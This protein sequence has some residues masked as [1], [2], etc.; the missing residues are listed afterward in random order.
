M[1][2]MSKVND[3]IESLKNI[4]EQMMGSKKGIS[5]EKLEKI[6]NSFEP[7]NIVLATIGRYDK[8]F[9][10]SSIYEIVGYYNQENNQVIDIRTGQS[11]TLLPV[12]SHE[13]TNDPRYR[14]IAD[15]MEYGKNYARS[16]HPLNAS[17]ISQFMYSRTFDCSTE[18]NV[19]KTLL[20]PY[21]SFIEV[22]DGGKNVDY[23]NNVENQINYFVNNC[24][25]QMSVV[26][27]EYVDQIVR[28]KKYRISKHNDNTN[29]RN[30]I[31]FVF[32]DRDMEYIKSLTTGEVQ[33]TCYY[34][35]QLDFIPKYMITGVNGVCAS[36]LSEKL[37]QDIKR[38]YFDTCGHLKDTK[39]TLQ[40]RGN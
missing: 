20:E 25:Y 15:E 17:S 11:Y 14:A 16:M 10:V 38:E 35:K 6:L 32:Y 34:G 40:K 29:E 5:I 26:P 1:K 3:I 24:V 13:S 7:D 21:K 9:Q 27:V 19:R 8:A 22:T 36:Q 12:S 2:L 37:L 28:G 39:K 18:Q 31:Y 4:K 30:D 33:P 23:F